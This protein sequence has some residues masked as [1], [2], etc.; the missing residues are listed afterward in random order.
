M[1]YLL[2]IEGM[3]FYRDDFIKKFRERFEGCM[4]EYAKLWVVEQLGLKDYWSHE[5]A[6]IA[7]RVYGLLDPKE[8]K[9]K[10]SWNRYA[11]AAEAWSEAADEQVKLHQG[12]SEFKNYTFFST[13]ELK[14]IHSYWTKNTPDSRDL[15]A[16]ILDRYFPREHKSKLLK[17][18][19]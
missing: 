9:V 2:K 18:L 16:E 6:R 10:G 4:K 8:T 11:A 5:V 12:I 13:K 17:F 14:T 1:R 15:A 19:K 7:K 3:A